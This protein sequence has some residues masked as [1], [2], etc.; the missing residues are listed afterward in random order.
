MTRLV[1]ADDWGVLYG[2]GLFETVRVYAGRLF[3]LSDHVDRMLHAAAALGFDEAPQRDVLFARICN[4]CRTMANGVVRVTLTVGNPDVGRPPTLFFSKRNLPYTNG[5][6][7]TGLA[8]AMAVERRDERSALV[9]HKT[10]NQ[11][12]NIIAFRDAKAKGA[13]EAL[14]FNSRGHL[15][16][17]SRSNV[18]IVVKDKVVT[19]PVDEGILPGITRGVVLDVLRELRIPVAEDVV[20]SADLLDCDECFLTSSVMEVMPV[21]RIDTQKVWSAPGTVTEA[22]AARY[23]ERV[24]RETASAPSREPARG[25]LAAPFA[26]RT[27]TLH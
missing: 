27:R 7:H 23:R 8:V 12:Q 15:A 14:F 20:T 19:P 13:A 16:E 17:G 21:S 18:F 4:R 24:R 1:A 11:L 2:Y 9:R 25:F 26:T 3:R 6:S 5:E 10:S 22:V